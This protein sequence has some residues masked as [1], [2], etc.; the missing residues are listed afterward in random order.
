VRSAIEMDKYN[1]IQYNTYI[2]TYIQSYIH[3]MSYMA[4]HVHTH[5]LDFAISRHEPS[6]GDG[7]SHMRDP[8]TCPCFGELPGLLGPHPWPDLD[9]PGSPSLS[10]PS[11]PCLQTPCLCVSFCLSVSIGVSL[12][13]SVSAFLIY[14]ESIIY[15]Y[16]SLFTSLRLKIRLFR[17]F[18]CLV[19]STSASFS[20]LCTLA[21]VTVWLT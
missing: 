9:Q 3:A 14:I 1:T 16:M 17:G 18:A 12:S 15:N 10:M 21:H 5:N 20:Y 2:H 11:M 13:L 19:H 4:C 6:Q 7:F 8:C